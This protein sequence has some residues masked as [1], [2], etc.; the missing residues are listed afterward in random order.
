MPPELKKPITK[1]KEMTCENCVFSHK[2]GDLVCN[3]PNSPNWYR[4]NGEFCSEGQWLVRR[5][6]ED[7]ETGE[8]NE[9]VYVERY[10]EIYSVFARMEIQGK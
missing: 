5:V 4:E 6:W 3:N 1:L 8:E 7:D 9:L 2:P 10:N